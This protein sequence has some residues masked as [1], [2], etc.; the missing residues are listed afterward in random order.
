MSNPLPAPNAA[1]AG[2]VWSG[3]QAEVLEAADGWLRVR[4][5]R[6][7]FW[8]AEADFRVVEQE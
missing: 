1:P 5:A 3:E 4:T 7:T 2:H 6:G 8:V